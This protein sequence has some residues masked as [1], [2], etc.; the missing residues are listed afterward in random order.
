MIG[1]IG[2]IGRIFSVS[3]TLGGELFAVA[4][5]FDEG[6][7]HGDELLIEEKV[8]LVDQA[9]EGVGAGGGV[10]VLQPGFV[11]FVAGAVSGVCGEIGGIGRI[12]FA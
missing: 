2:L 11:F 9:D 10:F 1:G 8:C 7:L 4:A 3:E 12:F 5:F 6:L